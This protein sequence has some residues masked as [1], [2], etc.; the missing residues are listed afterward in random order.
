VIILIVLVVNEAGIGRDRAILTTRARFRP[1]LQV[2]GA[3]ASMA[4]AGG[5][6]STAAPRACATLD[7]SRAVESHQHALNP[8]QWRVSNIVNPK[9]SRRVESLPHPIQSRT[10]PEPWRGSNTPYTVERL[11]HTLYSG[12]APIHPIQSRTHPE[13][14]RGSS[15]PY[16]VERLQHTLKPQS[17]RVSSSLASPVLR[18]AGRRKL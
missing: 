8:Q 4:T 17:W 16:R 13:P 1:W 12:G 7:E 6:L 5:L 10:H 11:Q 9:Q 14:W 2:G 3:Q 18:C 15:T